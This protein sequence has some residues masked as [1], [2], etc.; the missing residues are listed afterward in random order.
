MAEAAW[1]DSNPAL[2]GNNYGGPPLPH[3]TIQKNEDQ[4]LQKWS[5]HTVLRGLGFLGL[6]L[7]GF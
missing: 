1:Q 4:K 7:V 6:G 3:S 5:E 2:S